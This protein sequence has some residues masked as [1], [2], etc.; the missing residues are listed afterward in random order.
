[1]NKETKVTLTILIAEL[2]ECRNMEDVKTLLD[3]WVEANNL[4]PE[5][6][7]TFVSLEELL[8]SIKRC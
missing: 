6:V 7:T 3:C 1:M 4:H 2:Q 5:N 8:K